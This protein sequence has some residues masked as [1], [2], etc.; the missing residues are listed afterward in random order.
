M[1]APRKR[2]PDGRLLRDAAGEGRTSSL[3]EGWRAPER[4]DAGSGAYGEYKIHKVIVATGPR[5]GATWTWQGRETGAVLS[6]MSLSAFDPRVSA[7][8]P[9]PKYI[10]LLPLPSL[11]PLGRP[12][13]SLCPPAH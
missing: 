4:L 10:A 1:A 3:L 6:H 8:V 9:E 13:P 12:P 2:T 5:D 11:L 7:R